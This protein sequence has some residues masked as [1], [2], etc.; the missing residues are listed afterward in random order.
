[1]RVVCERILVK[2]P[3]Y[4][5]LMKVGIKGGIKT[6]LGGIAVLIFSD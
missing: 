3:F 1:M 5:I 4:L 6:S 2:G